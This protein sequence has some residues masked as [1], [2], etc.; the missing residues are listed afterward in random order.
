[1]AHSLTALCL[2]ATALGGAAAQIPISIA[3]DRIGRLSMLPLLGLAGV[4]LTLVV[5]TATAS[6]TAL[7][8]LM[9]SGSVWPTASL[10]GQRGRG[11]RRVANGVYTVSLSLVS[12]S[13]HE[14]QGL[15]ENA[16][17][18]GFYHAGFLIGPLTVSAS[19]SL[20]GS[21]GFIGFVTGIFALSL[22]LTK[23]SPKAPRVK[24]LG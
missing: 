19:L 2:S 14:E 11:Q 23:L 9:L 6:S 18:V 1:M 13:V 15:S 16:A 7:L 5:P 24:G 12:V 21:N 17:F 8:I 10:C 20:F 22:L 3:A 4:A